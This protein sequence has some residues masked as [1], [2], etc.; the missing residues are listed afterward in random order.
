MSIPLYI[1]I[2]TARQNLALF[3]IPSSQSVIDSADSKLSGVI[4]TAETILE[5]YQGTR[6]LKEQSNISKQGELHYPRP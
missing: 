5:V 4:D 2:D 6:F 1:V 3:L